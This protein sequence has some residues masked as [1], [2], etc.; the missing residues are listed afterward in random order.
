M[1]FVFL[2]RF[3]LIFVCLGYLV[4]VIFSW[5]CCNFLLQGELIMI[6]NFS[7]RRFVK[8]S[9]M[10]IFKWKHLATLLWSA[11]SSSVNSLKKGLWEPYK[12]LFHYPY[13][14]LLVKKRNIA[15][16]PGHIHRKSTKISILIKHIQFKVVS[17]L[18]CNK[19]TP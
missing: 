10:G 18:K 12:K 7:P 13:F 2:F 15:L 16:F 8:L 14:L 17:C 11:S 1:S 4:L 9:D 19:N 5:Y 3:S 6:S